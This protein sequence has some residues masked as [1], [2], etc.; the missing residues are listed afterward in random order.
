MVRSNYERKH[1][2]K[3][4]I[5]K[6]Y[7]DIKSLV[8]LVSLYHLMF[9]IFSQDQICVFENKPLFVSTFNFMF[10]KVLYM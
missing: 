5:V 10:Q 1:T 3:V 2:N 4:L 9:I 7:V 6:F 8:A